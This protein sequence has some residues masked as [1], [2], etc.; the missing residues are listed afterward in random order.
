MTPTAAGETSNPTVSGRPR[1]RPRPLRVPRPAH[2]SQRVASASPRSQSARDSSRVA[3]PASSRRTTSTS[4]VARLLVAELGG[5]AHARRSFCGP[6]RRRRQLPAGDADP[7]QLAGATS[8]GVADDPP[9][10]V[11]HH[12]VPA[13][14]GRRRGQRPRRAPA[15]ARARRR[16]GAAGRPTRRRAR[17]RRPA[18]SLGPADDTRDGS[19][20]A[21]PR[22]QGGEPALLAVEPPRRARRSIARARPHPASSSATSGTTR[23][24]ASVGVEARTS[25]TRSSSGVST[26]WP[27]ALTTGVRA[28]ATARTSASLLNG[29]R[30]S[31]EP[32]PRAMTMTS[33]SGSRS[34]SSTAALTSA[35]AFGALHGDLADARTRRRA[36]GAGRSR[37]RRARRR[38]P[39]RRPARR[40]AAGT[41]AAAC[42]RARTGPRRRA[43]RLRCSTRASSSPTPTGR[44]SSASS[45]SVPRL[46]Q[47]SGLA[48][49]TT[50]AP[51]ASGAASASRTRAAR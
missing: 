42:A 6:L 32:P 7:Q 1:R 13:R 8:L 16:R 4:C 39:G 12:G 46:A 26:S 24:A 50:R 43:A 29:S 19:A 2:C 22:P 33:T 30:S 28:P 18:T 9:V 51:S 20:S 40:A 48:W 45:V 38:W 21:G 44:I 35:T 15:G 14:Q 10:G 27:I 25:A 47:K 31:T 34:S 36:S 3:P 23:L 41:A 5:L 17:S 49:T 37:R 11:L